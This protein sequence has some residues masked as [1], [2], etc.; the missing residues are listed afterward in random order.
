[1]PRQTACSLPLACCAPLSRAPKHPSIRQDLTILDLSVFSEPG[2]PLRSPGVLATAA[3]MRPIL[4]VASLTSSPS[5]VGAVTR[6]A[7]VTD[8]LSS[9][10]ST[11][12]IAAPASA[13]TAE[14]SASATTPKPRRRPR[15]VSLAGA[16]ETD[17][18]AGGGGGNGDCAVIGVQRGS[19]VGIVSFGFESFQMLMI[20]FYNAKGR[21][22][23]QRP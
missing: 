16:G 6:V 23:K 11:T 8:L 17:G 2:T 3:A 20:F 19:M 22:A 7:V 4:V 12:P 5:A 14:T 1:M 18:G 13:E 21:C 15:G 9:R 10:V